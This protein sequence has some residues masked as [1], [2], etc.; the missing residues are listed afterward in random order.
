[1]LYLIL[2]R[3]GTDRTKRL[4][5]Y[6]DEMTKKAEA[7]LIV[8]EQCSFNNEKK[9]LKQLGAKKG[10]KNKGTELSESLQAYF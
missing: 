3:N 7:V 1:M 10:C 2:G 9:L 6:I 5:Q 8:P 4:H